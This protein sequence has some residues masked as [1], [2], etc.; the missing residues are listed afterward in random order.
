MTAELFQQWLDKLNS[1][2]KRESRSILLFVDNCTSHPDLQFSNVKLVFLPPNTTS[3]LQPCDVGVIQAT[4]IHYRK[5]LLR[6]VLFHMNEASGASD[7][8][9]RVN[10]L[11]AIMWLKN[12]WDNVKPTTIQK[13][14]A[15]C[16]FSE[17]VFTD[18]DDTAIDSS[19]SAFVEASGAS[20]EVYANFDHDLAT[21]R[22]I[23]EEWEA[24][25]LENARTGTSAEDRA[26]TIEDENEE[27][28]EEEVVIQ[29]PIL[30]AGTT[31]SYLDDLRDF[32]LYCQCPELLDLISK[33]RTT[34]EKLM[35]DPDK[36]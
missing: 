25:L 14:F 12:A 4:K 32:A 34:I 5:L 10:V 9:K 16:G 13:C 18:P 19:L 27:E 1:K 2:M 7:L 8:A 31:I 30:T 11:D 6:H 20:W 33:T 28:E 26:D 23:G 36:L 22:T 21:N 15:K 3:K 29:K 35:C 17:A 24:A